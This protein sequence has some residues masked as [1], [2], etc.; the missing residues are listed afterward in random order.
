MVDRK[1]KEDLPEE[2]DTL[3]SASR[4]INLIT[5]QSQIF[6]SILSFGVHSKSEERYN[7][8]NL[9]DSEESEGEEDIEVGEGQM[10]PRSLFTFK[11]LILDKRGLEIIA[12][13]MKVGSLRDCNIVLHL[14]IA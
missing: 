2:G 4:I 3:D 12:P 11:A 13:I 1:D 5:S 6:K 14:N 7:R 8:D 9:G 10:A